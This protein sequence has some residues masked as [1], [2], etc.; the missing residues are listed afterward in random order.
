MNSENRY[1]VEKRAE[2]LSVG[3]NSETLVQR[4]NRRAGEKAQPLRSL[5]TLS[6]N[7]SSVPIPA[8]V[9]RISQSPGLYSGS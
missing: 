3:E 4:K 9:L 6:Q 5:E 1:N 8:L 2:F 7:V